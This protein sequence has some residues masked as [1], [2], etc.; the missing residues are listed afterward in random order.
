MTADFHDCGHYMHVL[1]RMRHK[2]NDCGWLREGK[3]TL[4]TSVMG[5]A[6]LRMTAD[7]LH[8]MLGVV[9]MAWL[10]DSVSFCLELSSW[11]APSV[12]NPDFCIIAAVKITASQLVKS[13]SQT[14][15][16]DK[17][18]PQTERWCKIHKS[19]QTNPFLLHT[20]K[21][22]LKIQEYQKKTIIDKNT[23]KKIQWT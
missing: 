23:Y 21:K 13:S 2:A 12:T 5:A 1:L 17:K 19:H 15:P 4:Q 7:V 9:S 3:T 20:T 14:S 22:T 6:W 8:Q 18:N 11:T 16:K 10:R